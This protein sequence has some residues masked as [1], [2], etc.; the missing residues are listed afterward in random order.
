M[1]NNIRTTWICTNL[2]KI[3][4]S[5]AFLHAK[6]WRKVRESLIYKKFVQNRAGLFIVFPLRIE[7]IGILNLYRFDWNLTKLIS[8]KYSGDTFGH[9]AQL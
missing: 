1:E 7:I 6:G 9:G 8:E 5:R 2:L 4:L 3:K